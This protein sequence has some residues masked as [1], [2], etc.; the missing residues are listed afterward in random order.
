MS[1]LMTRRFRARG[2]MMLAV[3]AAVHRYG[4]AL[5]AFVRRWF[6]Q[7]GE[8]RARPHP[9]TKRYRAALEHD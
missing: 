6:A 9:P 3:I 7:R 4:S 5:T 2:T 1:A 8:R